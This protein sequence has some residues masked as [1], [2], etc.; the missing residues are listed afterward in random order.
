[1]ENMQLNTLIYLTSA[2]LCV[3]C[4]YD[5]ILAGSNIH[6]TY[7]KLTEISFCILNIGLEH[8]ILP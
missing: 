6:S 3:I 8:S 1:M 2:M 4:N 5:Y 7:H